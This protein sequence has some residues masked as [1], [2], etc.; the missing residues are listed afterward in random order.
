MPIYII[1]MKIPSITITHPEEEEEDRGW[2]ITGTH[3]IIL[4]GKVKGNRPSLF[5]DNSRVSIDFAFTTL[6]SFK[7][8]GLCARTPTGAYYVI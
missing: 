7:V 2:K 5:K 4:V 6:H 3:P 8:T 1:V